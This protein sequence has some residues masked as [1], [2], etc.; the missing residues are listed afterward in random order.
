MEM[1]NVT[2]SYEKKGINRVKS[3]TAFVDMGKITTI[4]G[5]NGCG[6]S[7]LLSLMARNYLPDRGEIVLDGKSIETFKPK[8]FA[9]K[10]AVVHQ[11]N[12][13]PY[14]M[15]V[16][17]LASFGRI[18]Y[19]SM[20]S[21]KKEEDEEAVEW[22][23]TCTNLLDKRK[24]TIAALSGG[25]RQRVWIAMA[26]AQ[27][28]PILFLDEPTTYLDIYYQFEILELIKKL[29][30]R[31]GLTIVMVLHDINQAVRYSDSIWAMREG[32]LILKGKPEEMMTEQ[33]I[34]QIYGVEVMI[35]S[36]EEAGMY[37]VPIGI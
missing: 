10:L 23:L 12:E 6:K 13:A 28:T 29:N 1:N 34:K 21:Q 8:E 32:E 16:E 14:D 7:T 18:P 9:K 15:T 17:R 11:Q 31:H 33:V 20:L 30:E 19:Q 36:D 26:L 24:K 35:K 27:K 25:E 5:P 4:I 3:L 37:I 2:F 22:A